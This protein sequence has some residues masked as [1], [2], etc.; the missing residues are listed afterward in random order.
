MSSRRERS[1]ETAILLALTAGAFAVRVVG[2]DQNLYGDELFT[3]NDVNGRS[4]GGALREVRVGLEDNPPLFFIFAWLSAQLGDPT[5]WIRLPSLLLGTALV[6]LI[7]LLGARVLSRA[8]GLAA[9]AIVAFSPFM[10]FYGTEARA[11][12]TLMFL[13]ALSTLLLVR[14][15]DGRSRWWWVAYAICGCAVLYT[16]YTGVFV[17]VAQAAW[18]FWAHRRLI[19]PLLL[20]FAAMVAGYAPWLVTELTKE[21]AFTRLVG[22]FTLHNSLDT[23]VR[24]LIGQPGTSVSRLPGDLLLA[25]FLATVAVALLVLLGRALTSR[26][27][28]HVERLQALLILTAVATPCGLVAFSLGGNN[29]FIPRNLSAS[30]PAVLL[31]L[32][33]LLTSLRGAVAVGLTAVALAVVAVAGGKALD[34]PSVRGTDTRRV[35]EFIDERARPGDPVFQ[36]KPFLGGVG[37]PLARGL[38]AYLERPHRLEWRGVSDAE[39]WEAGWRGANVFFVTTPIFGYLPPLPRGV[40]PGKCFRLGDS[41]SVPSAPMRVGIYSVPPARRMCAQV[42]LGRRAPGGGSVRLVHHDGH[43]AVSPWLDRAQLNVTREVDGFVDEISASPQA[44][45][46]IGW[47]ADLEREVPGEWVLVFSHGRL[48]AGVTPAEARPD[49]A[50]GHGVTLAKSGYKTVIDVRSGEDPSELAPLQV[51]A[52]SEGRASRLPLTEPARNG[53]AALRDGSG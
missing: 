12:A 13:S 47:A 32:G 26:P 16:H 18:A 2:V 25:A 7:Y 8:A 14:A 41:R 50:K 5:I 6:P 40:G 43:W 20:T 28:L 46:V 19:R 24:A 27:V 29:I 44:V 37:S 51:I 4:L 11:Y 21:P 52:V 9:A 53:A 22:P 3:F 23:V 45:T 15:V 48:L 31:L 10:V 49:V 1:W 17:L 36:P 30:L 38:E 39:V 35:A 33:W 34:Q 42:A